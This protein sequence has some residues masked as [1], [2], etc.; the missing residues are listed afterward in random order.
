MINFSLEELKIIEKLRKVKAYKY[1]PKDELIKILSEPYP[2]ISIEK[3]RK[4]FCESRDRFKSKI[5][6]IRRNLYEIENKKNLSTT[7]IKE[8]EKNLLE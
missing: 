7:K 5:K 1:K 4:K 3:I 6:E 2:K 8:I